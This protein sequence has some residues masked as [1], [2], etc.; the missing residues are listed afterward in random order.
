[1]CAAIFCAGVFVE[2]PGQ[3]DFHGIR[4]GLWTNGRRDRLAGGNSLGWRTGPD[5]NANWVLILLRRQIRR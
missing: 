1:M 3:G 2:N 5:K 4:C